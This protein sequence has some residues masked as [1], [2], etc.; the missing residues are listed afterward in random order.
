MRSIAPNWSASTRQPFF[1]TLNRISISQRARY[2]SIS[3]TTAA[4]VGVGQQA[5]FDGFDTSGRRQ[6]V[7]HVAPT[8]AGAPCAPW[9]R[10]V[11]ESQIRSA[12]VPRWRKLLALRQ[13]AVVR[14]AHQ[15]VHW[16]AQGLGEGHQRHHVRFAIRGFGQC[17]NR[18]GSRAGKDRSGK[19]ESR[20][21]ARP[22][23]RTG[24]GGGGRGN[25]VANTRATDYAATKRAL[26][27]GPAA[28]HWPGCY[29]TR[30]RNS[31]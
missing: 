26:R 10:A 8:A 25:P 5:P 1:S 22:S 31:T 20:A 17:R 23:G 21:G 16:R 2:Q 28:L 7:R 13:A 19:G 15:P 30:M 4:A 18:P 12:R 6:A 27:P 29:I 11:P 24:P 14:C 9:H 3:S